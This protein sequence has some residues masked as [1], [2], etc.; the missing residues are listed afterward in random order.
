MRIGFIGNTNN[1]PF[2]LAR[3][4]KKMGHDVQVIVTSQ[5]KLHRPE[6]RYPDILYPYPEWIHEIIFSSETLYVTC[7]VEQMAAVKLL[8]SCDFVVLNDLGISMATAINRPYLAMLTGSDLSFY[9]NFA[10]RTRVASAMT[11]RN[12]FKRWYGLSQWTK[13]VRAQREGVRNAP[14]IYHFSPGLIP[15]SDTLLREI[16]VKASQRVF[17]LMADVGE[18][19]LAPNPRGE[20]LQS[21]CA[22]RLTWVGPPLAGDSP[23]DFKGSDIMLRGIGEFWGRHRRTLNIHLVRKGRHLAETLDLI[24]ELQIADQITWHD[25]MSQSEVWRQY[26]LCNFVFEQLGDGLVT[27]AGLEA[28]A[29]GRAVIA[30][31]RPE[32]LGPMLGDSSPICQARTAV[33]VCAH[34][35]RFEFDRDFLADIGLKSHQWVRRHFAPERAAE[36]VLQRLNSIL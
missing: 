24:S 28:M 27:M 11:T 26:G 30:N 9:C 1:Y 29:A 36:L 6:H 4:F 33:E 21:F 8:Q 3:A 5:N 34:L 22:T 15:E 7:V 35:E 17:F 23:L 14:L 32:I 13:L 20:T 18:I 19:K 10:S 2:M 16:G 25:E 12:P 31:G